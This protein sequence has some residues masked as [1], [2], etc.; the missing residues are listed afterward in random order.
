MGLIVPSEVIG[1]SMTA[2]GSRAIV[3]NPAPS[4]GSSEREWGCL[5]GFSIGAVNGGHR[6][7]PR[8]GGWG[9]RLPQHREEVHRGAQPRHLWGGGD[10]VPRE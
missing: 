7:N 4:G 9:V 6:G 3:K 5:G 1:E 10:G 8:E 2:G